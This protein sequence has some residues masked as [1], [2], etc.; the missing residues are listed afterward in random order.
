MDRISKIIMFILSFLTGFIPQLV[1]FIESAVT[2][3]K[4]FLE[5]I[6]A[7][8]AAEDEIANLQ[9]M[10]REE[11]VRNARAKFP[12][13]PEPLIRLTIEAAVMK[14]KAKPKDVEKAKKEVE[15]A[16]KTYP[17]LFGM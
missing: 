16:K 9:A 5:G 17:G 7:K 1:T 12:N 13:T 15:M 3:I 8:G 2:Q 10:K 6:A 11:L 4:A 14:K